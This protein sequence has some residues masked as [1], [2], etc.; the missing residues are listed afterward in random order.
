MPGTRAVWMVWYWGSNERDWLTNRQHVEVLRAGRAVSL[1]L[2]RSNPVYPMM[3]RPP[4]GL[5]VE[6]R[7]KEH[8][9]SYDSRFRPLKRREKLV[10]RQRVDLAKFIQMSE[11]LDEAY[12]GL[13]PA[14]DYLSHECELAENAL[15]KLGSKFGT[16]SDSN[17]AALFALTYR[18]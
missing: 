14:P 10:A 13:K 8:I 16:T 7:S 12:A 4:D 5:L 11:L 15:S 18:Q 3:Y 9:L 6:W 17:L 1:P 2:T